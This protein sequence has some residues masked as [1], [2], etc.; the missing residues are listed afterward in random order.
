MVMIK[1]LVTD[2]SRVLLFP[3][4]E[5][6]HGGLNSLNNQLFE[7]EPDYD[8]WKH[9]KLNEELLEYYASLELPKFIF[10][11]ETIQE[12]PAVEAKLSS[13]FKGV[14]SAKRL[15]LS[16]TDEKA[17]RT[18]ANE[19][20]IEPSEIVYVDDNKN[21]IEAAKRAGGMTIHFE[22]NKDV[23]GIAAV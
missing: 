22:S 13:V 3:S 4:D 15:G 17:Y 16:K 11:S 5:T 7:T 12:H 10:T 9:F 18:I 21:N 2:F 1:A 6:N 14:F 19:L 23:I 8:F 20:G